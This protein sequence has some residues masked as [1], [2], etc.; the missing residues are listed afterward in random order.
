MAFR[1]YIIR[2]GAE[3]AWLIRICQTGKDTTYTYMPDISMAMIFQTLHEARKIAKACR[4]Q[5]QALRIDKAGQPY[6]ED[7]KNEKK[8]V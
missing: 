8:S 5:V 1:K 2:N 4:G 7:L 6:G 3:Q